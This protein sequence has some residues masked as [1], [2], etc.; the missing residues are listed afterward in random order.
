MRR[1]FRAAVTRVQRQ[2]RAHKHWVA[3][4]AWAKRLAR[5]VLRRAAGAGRT[6]ATG[7]RASTLRAT[8]HSRERAEVPM[9]VRHARWGRATKPRL[10]LA[11]AVGPVLV[12]MLDRYEVYAG[13]GDG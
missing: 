9:V 10:H 4:G 2:L 13:L 5:E 1:K 11:A 8:V 7:A 3:A 12:D 6:A